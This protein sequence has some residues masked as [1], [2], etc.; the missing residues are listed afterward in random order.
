MRMSVVSQ[1][2]AHSSSLPSSAEALP[3]WIQ[4]TKPLF[5]WN[6]LEDSLTLQAIEPLLRVIPDD[7][8]L[9]S[10]RASRGTGRN[11]HSLR[12]LRGVLLWS[13]A[14][15]YPAIEACLAELR[16]NE[17]LR[18]LIGIASE[19]EVPRRRNLPRFL[20]ALGRQQISRR[21]ATAPR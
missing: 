10:L 19:D 5:D 13:I 20:E 12:T 1:G 6:F 18:E 4:Q 3:L 8:L 11:D 16:H 15:R 17:S 14:L 21:G 7:S 2:Q 9:V